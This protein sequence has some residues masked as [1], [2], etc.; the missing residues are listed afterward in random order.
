MTIYFDSEHDGRKVAEAAG[1]FFNP[2]C[3]KVISRVVGE[4]LLG[5]VIYQEFT[6]ESIGMHVAG[7]AK[8]WLNRDFLWA[9]FYYPF[10]QL[11]VKRIFAQ[12]RETNEYTLNFD[13]KLGFKIVTKI[14]GTYPDGGTYLIS[15]ERDECRWLKLTP[16]S[17]Q[18]G[19]EI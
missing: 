18:S 14:D 1:T 8:S 3:D 6:G 5:G 4:K 17:L 9:S 7:F 16:K 19:Q 11:D 12:V 15:M 13:L 2:E 10:V